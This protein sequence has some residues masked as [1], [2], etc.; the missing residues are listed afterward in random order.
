MT[1]GAVVG[2]VLAWR[3]PRRNA[4]VLSVRALP[5]DPARVFE[6]LA[7]LHNHWLLEDRFVELGG[8]DPGD[9][10]GPQGGLVRLKGPLGI[11]RD[12]RTQVLEAQPPT[13]GRPGCLAGRADVGTAT[14]SRISWHIAA[15]DR[16]SLVTLAATVER[17]SRLDRVLLLFGRWWL[18]QTFDRALA[19]LDQTLR[20]GGTAVRPLEAAPKR[21]DRRLPGCW[22]ASGG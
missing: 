2:A 16:G 19:N 12:A 22:P 21:V 17:V 6:F 10:N 14:T 11:N 3:R 1:Y 18:Q 20:R 4:D 5:A 8:L 9:G 13:F 15:Q 7:D